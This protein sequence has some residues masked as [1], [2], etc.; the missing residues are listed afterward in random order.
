M[1]LMLLVGCGQQQRLNTFQEQP[2]IQQVVSIPEGYEISFKNPVGLP[3][4]VWTNQENPAEQYT[5]KTQT[6]LRINIPSNRMS[7]RFAYAYAER[8]GVISP[9]VE[10]TRINPPPYPT[11]DCE[12]TAM[13][14]TVSWQATHGVKPYSA[15]LIRHGKQ[16]LGPF[17]TEQRTVTIQAEGQTIWLQWISAEVRGAFKEVSCRVEADGRSRP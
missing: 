6:P 8:L 15:W 5:V 16:E 10:L 2:S 9:W 7:L 4:I 3:I 14:H 13:G 11:I 1:I 12:Q 17:S